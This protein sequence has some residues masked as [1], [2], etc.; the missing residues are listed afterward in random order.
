MGFK[1]LLQGKKNI[2]DVVD[3]STGNENT[4]TDDEKKVVEKNETN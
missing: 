4:L 2:P 1:D 3:A